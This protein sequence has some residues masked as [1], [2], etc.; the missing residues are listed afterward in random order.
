MIVLPLQ[1]SISIKGEPK[2]RL[3][4]ESFPETID[5]DYTGSWRVGKGKATAVRSAFY[6]NGEF[7]DIALVLIFVAGMFKLESV[8]E[9]DDFQSEIDYEAELQIMEEKARWLQAL[10]FPK[11]SRKQDCDSFCSL[12][13]ETHTVIWRMHFH[14]GL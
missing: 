5:E 6:E 10:C 4:F 8:L 12:L 13:E 3:P 2:S 7:S 1:C 11:P 9:G 14:H